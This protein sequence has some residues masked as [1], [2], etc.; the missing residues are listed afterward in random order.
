MNAESSLNDQKSFSYASKKRIDHLLTKECHESKKCASA[1][2]TRSQQ[3]NNRTKQIRPEPDCNRHNLMHRRT[4]THPASSSGTC[5]GKADHGS[6]SISDPRCYLPNI[7][8]VQ[9]DHEKKARHVANG[10]R[11]HASTPVPHRDHY[12]KDAETRQHQNNLNEGRDAHRKV[13]G[14][15]KMWSNP[16]AKRRAGEYPEYPCIQIVYDRQKAKKP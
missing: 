15:V 10:V 8:T 5:H 1:F 16:F 2:Q 11:K 12:R 6:R 7:Q 9:V 14:I 3:R 13:C 4:H